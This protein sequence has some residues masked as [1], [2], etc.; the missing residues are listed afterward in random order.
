MNE[1]GFYGMHRRN[2]VQR[3]IMFIAS[4]LICLALYFIGA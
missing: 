3:Q 2:A 4:T 1:I